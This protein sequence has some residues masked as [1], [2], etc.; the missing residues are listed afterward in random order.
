MSRA[1]E[2]RPFAPV[3][4]LTILAAAE[5]AQVQGRGRGKPTTRRCV[6]EHLGF[7]WN[8]G[9]ARKLLPQLLALEA[10]GYLELGGPAG[11][12]GSCRLTRQ[13]LNALQRARRAEAP[14]ASVEALPESPQHRNW[15]HAR[16][17]A[18]AGISEFLGAV[19]TEVQEAETVLLRP[20]LGSSGELMQIGNRLQ[21]QFWRL[22]SATYCL[23]EWPEPNERRRDTDKLGRSGFW[24]FPRRELTRWPDERL[25]GEEGGLLWRR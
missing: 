17:V 14:E 9:T 21:L 4:D 6:A 1:T 5:R 2:L 3:P 7:A 24:P 8:S 19:T 13:G 18:A 22:A 16:T 15:R 12:E 10:A 23:R 20:R 11:F 25:F